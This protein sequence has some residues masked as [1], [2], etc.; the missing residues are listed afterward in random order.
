MTVKEQLGLVL[1]ASRKLNL[2]SEEKINQVLEDVAQ[3]AIDNTPFIL[4]ENAK[5]DRKSV[6]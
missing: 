3:A 2:V 4:G 5:E 1:K 6:V